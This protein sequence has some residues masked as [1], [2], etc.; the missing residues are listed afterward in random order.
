MAIYLVVMSTGAGK[1]LCYQLPAALSSRPGL[2]LLEIFISYR[3][4]LGIV[5][6]VQPLLSLVEDQ[7]IQL[8]RLNIQATTLNQHSTKEEVHTLSRMILAT[9]IF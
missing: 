9:R 6:V 7:L 4:I 1:S 8:R 5:L 3:A 2:L